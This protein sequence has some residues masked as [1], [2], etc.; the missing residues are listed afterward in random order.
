MEGISEQAIDALAAA[1]RR[2]AEGR[3]L[4]AALQALAEA[5]AEAVGAEAAVIR[6]ADDS[7]NLTARTVVARSEALEAELAGSSFPLSE[8]TE[9][10][11]TGDRLP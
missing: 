5:V 11:A 9:D 1:G 3:D 2:A 4:G 10:I 8:L 6:I 7:G